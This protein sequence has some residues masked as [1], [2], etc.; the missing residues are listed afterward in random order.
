MWLTICLTLS[1]ANREEVVHYVVAAGNHAK[2]ALES[3][4]LK[5]SAF[6][7]TVIATSARLASQIALAD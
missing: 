1:R 7:S 4:E 3:L 6:K 2:E 5:L